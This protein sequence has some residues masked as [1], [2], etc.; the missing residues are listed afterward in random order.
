MAVNLPMKVQLY[1]LAPLSIVNKRLL[2]MQI[3]HFE[4]YLHVRPGLQTSRKRLKS[5]GKRIPDRNLITPL[6]EVAHH[7]TP[8]PRPYPM[9]PWE[10]E[11]QHIRHFK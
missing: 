8:L 4:K 3:S 5:V 1:Y 6:A 2:W 11:S 9:E 10:M 7:F